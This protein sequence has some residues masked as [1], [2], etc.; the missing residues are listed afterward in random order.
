MKYYVWQDMPIRLANAQIHEQEPVTRPNGYHFDQLIY[1]VSGKG[2]FTDINNNTHQI[3]TGQI[4]YIPM[5]VPHSYQPDITGWETVY[6]VFCGQNLEDGLMSILGFSNECK[7]IDTNGIYHKDI[8]DLIL[9]LAYMQLKDNVML[10]LPQAMLVY[11]LVYYVRCCMLNIDRW[12][13]S[14][15]RRSIAPLLEYVNKLFYNDISIAEMSE[16]LDISTSNI[17]TLFHKELNLSPYKYITKLRLEHAKRLLILH[18]DVTL[19]RICSYTGINKKTLT[20]N[21]K[22]ET[23]CTP[24]E[25]RRKYAGTMPDM[26]CFI[27]YKTE[28]H[29]IQLRLP[30]YA[31][32]AGHIFDL[33]YM[34]NNGDNY[35]AG[36]SFM[37]CVN[38]QGVFTDNDGIEHL[39]EKNDILFYRP[40]QCIT[41]E[42]VSESFNVLWI[43]F[44]GK[45]IDMF[46]DYLGFS[47]SNILRDP[48]SSD[49]SFAD[50]IEYMYLRKWNND[51]ETEL[52]LSV[53]VYEL[54][55]QASLALDAASERKND[56]N[57]YI[58]LQPA[59]DIINTYYNMDIAIPE[60]AEAVGLSNNQFLR[61][62]N[63]ATGK[64][65]KQYVT[66]MRI[67]RAKYLLIFFPTKK[68]SEIASECGFSTNSYFCRVFKKQLGIT[69]EKYRALNLLRGIKNNTADGYI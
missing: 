32:N 49:Y 50:A 38:G 13:P 68:L 26:Y 28:P 43:R 60:L 46:L 29:P 56:I 14:P 57:Q 15:A 47:G 45:Y 6:A 18:P 36:Y 3:S 17:F 65:P 37:Y 69:P 54:I 31:A 64:T 59:F 34:H 1:T 11:K 67:E 44:G 16:K 58:R 40:S 27:S 62:F 22:K 53:R 5:N 33:N 61:L 24:A 12:S 9:R 7:I 21:L 39:I 41:I 52:D 66:E 48:N 8:E 2:T 20:R 35:A 42:S 25:Y 19:N 4:I 63:N 55:I 30:V 51:F 10:T 23:C